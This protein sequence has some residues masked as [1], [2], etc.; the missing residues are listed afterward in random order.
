MKLIFKVF[1]ISLFF[2]A[3]LFAQEN[4]HNIYSEL[5]NNAIGLKVK[6]TESGNFIVTAT[7][8]ETLKLIE[9]DSNGKLLSSTPISNTG[10]NVKA[11]DFTSDGGIVYINSVERGDSSDYYL[12]LLDSSYQSSWSNYLGR[13][14]NDYVKSNLLA[15]SNEHF[16]VSFYFLETAQKLNLFYFNK[17]GDKVWERDFVNKPSSRAK[18]QLLELNNNTYLAATS[19]T[20]ININSSGDSL[21]SFNPNKIVYDVYQYESNDNIIVSIPYFFKTISSTGTLLNEFQT[22]LYDQNTIISFEDD[23]SIAFDKNSYTVFTPS[24]ELENEIKTFSPAT[25]KM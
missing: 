23:Y 11:I 14:D 8:D 13:Q 18:Y 24:F 19:T 2:S 25:A 9:I 3:I 10:I 5:G 20:I 21:W 15:T 12:V 16:L 17:F 22:T 1:F 4:F 6:K 7:I